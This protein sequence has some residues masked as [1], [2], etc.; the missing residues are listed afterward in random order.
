MQNPNR[1]PKHPLTLNRADHQTAHE[2]E[3]GDGDEHLNHTPHKQSKC[4]HTAAQ[5]HV[6]AI[7]DF[8]R[9]T[10]RSTDETE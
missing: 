3:M 1:N 8:G 10:N 2:K 6:S 4:K 7:C 5:K 9:K